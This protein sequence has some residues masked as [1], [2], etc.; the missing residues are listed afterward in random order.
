MSEDVEVKV[1]G[2]DEL[3]DAMEKLPARLAGAAA[4]PA[5]SAAGQV[6]E[7]AMR[8]TVPRDTGALADSIT[9]KVHVSSNL[10][11]MSVIVG[12]EYKG[13]GTQDP[14]VRAM[15]LEFGTRKMAPRPFMRQA[16][17][18]SKDA[19]YNAAV[20]VLRAVLERLPK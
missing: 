16:F 2:L 3:A 17:A 14:G 12:P 1:E 19:A 10:S 6:F 9:R 20:A 7:A 13:G 11:S 18:M 8:S 15:F 5:L 4:R